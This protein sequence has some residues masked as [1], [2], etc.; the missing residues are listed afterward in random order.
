MPFGPLA[1]GWLTGSYA[2]GEPLPGGLADDAAPGALR[3]F[4]DRPVFDGL[5]ALAAEAGA[6]GVDMATLAFAWVLSHPDVS[7]AVCG[8]SRPAHLDPVLRR[9]TLPLAADERERIG[10]FFGM[11]R[12]AI[13]SAR[14]RPPA[15]AGGRLHRPDGARCSRRSPASELYNP[16]RFVFRPP[17]DADAHGPDAGLPLRRGRRSTR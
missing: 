6:R 15:A 13:L 17:G 3:H 4:L 12:S 16:L 5:E 10:S 14:R 11:S 8:P 1:G 7:G 9:S 2:R